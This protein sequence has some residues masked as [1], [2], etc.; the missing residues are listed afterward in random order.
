MC[1]NVREEY[2]CV[3]RVALCTALETH[4]SVCGVTTHQ[5]CASC[6]QSILS[7]T[8]MRILFLS[9]FKVGTI[10][11]FWVSTPAPHVSC[12]SCV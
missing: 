12:V 8:P 11:F 6:V 4:N 5:W 2:P 10:F 3:Y 9:L 7:P 1:V